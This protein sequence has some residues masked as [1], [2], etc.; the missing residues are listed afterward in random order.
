MHG[1]KPR[2][3]SL[4]IL[5]SNQLHLLAANMDFVPVQL[6]SFYS[7]KS[8]N[9]QKTYLWYLSTEDQWGMG[10]LSSNY[11]LHTSKMVQIS[12]FFM[13]TPPKYPA[14]ASKLNGKI[15]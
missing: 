5:V 10:K 14:G 7:R 13:Y 3:K 11:M 12:K 9:S 4:E 6:K 2:M 8:P 1:A 15:L